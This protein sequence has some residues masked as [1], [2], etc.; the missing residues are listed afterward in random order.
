[1]VA[2][3]RPELQPILCRFDLNW[4]DAIQPPRHHLRFLRPGTFASG[5]TCRTVFPREEHLPGLVVE[6]VRETG[7]GQAAA[8]ELT[9]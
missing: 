1:L 2:A 3:G 4:V 5:A 9:G 7:R 8:D 6:A